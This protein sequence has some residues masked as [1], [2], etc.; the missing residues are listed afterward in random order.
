MVVGI[1]LKLSDWA[2][3]SNRYIRPDAS[4]TK[5]INNS[6]TEIREWA[7]FRTTCVNRPRLAT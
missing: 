5:I 6:K 7:L 4:T 1:E 2:A 3:C